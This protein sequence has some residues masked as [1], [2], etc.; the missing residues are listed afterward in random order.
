MAI[1][2]T[3]EF[4]QRAGDLAEKYGL[5]GFNVV[6]LATAVTLHEKLASP[7]TFSCYDIKLQ[8]ASQ[9]EILDQPQ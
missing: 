6:H 7:V 8:N 5:R 2:V 3:S 1:H 4:V 9:R